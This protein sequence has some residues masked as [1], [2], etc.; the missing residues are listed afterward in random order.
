ML[1]KILELVCKKC[2]VT[3][4]WPGAVPNGSLPGKV[5][6]ESQPCND[7][8]RRNDTNVLEESHKLR[9]D[10]KLRVTG[11]RLHETLNVFVHWPVAIAT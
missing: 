5:L 2:K 9:H 11:C 10:M 6:G 1:K 4:I 8:G 7:C 3:K